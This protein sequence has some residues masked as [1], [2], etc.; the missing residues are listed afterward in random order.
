MVSEDKRKTSKIM[1]SYEV[2]FDVCSR[3]SVISENIFNILQCTIINIY[4][5]QIHLN[6]SVYILKCYMLILEKQQSYMSLCF[7]DFFCYV[8][9]AVSIIFN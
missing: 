9:T 2:T 7:S 6:A 4:F 8:Y 1:S 5:F 3:F